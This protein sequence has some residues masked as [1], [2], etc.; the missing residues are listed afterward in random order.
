MDFRGST[1][2]TTWEPPESVFAHLPWNFRSTLVLSIDIRYYSLHWEGGLNS[3]HLGPSRHYVLLLICSCVPMKVITIGVS[4]AV[5]NLLCHSQ[6]KDNTH[7]NARHSQKLGSHNWSVLC[8]MALL[9]SLK[10]LQIRI[11]TRSRVYLK[12][13]A[14]QFNIRVQEPKHSLVLYS[15]GDMDIYFCTF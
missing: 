12:T 7:F 3:F 11:R 5:I 15:H 2:M 6:R 10:E 4:S 8:W 9:H 14:L 1:M 13:I